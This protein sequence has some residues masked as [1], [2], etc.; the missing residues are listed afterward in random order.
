MNKTV[1]TVLLIV[2]VVLIIG[3]IG[4]A[5]YALIPAPEKDGSDKGEGVT[6]T[7]VIHDDIEYVYNEDGS[8]KSEIYYKDNKYNGQKDYYKGEKDEYITVF[9]ADGEEISSSVSK[10]NGAGSLVSV[11]T[12]E[13]GK[14]AELSEYDYYDDLRTLAKKTVKTYEGEDELAEKTYY[15]EAGKKTRTCKYLNGTLTE[16][17]YFDEKGNVIENGGETVEE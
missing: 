14:I 11:T 4:A 7:E 12:Y 13:G 17:I 9:N 8:L 5:V 15:S 1:K 2:A 10:F 6:T 3:G 16:E